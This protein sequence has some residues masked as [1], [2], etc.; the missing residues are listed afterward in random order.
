[1]VP[2]TQEILA[3][4]PAKNIVDPWR[5]YHY[6]V[7]SER[8]AAGAIEQVATIFLTNREC[9]FRCT[10]CDLWRNTLDEPTPLGAVPA[11]IDYALVRLPPADSIKLYNSGNFFD[12]QAIPPADH[13]AIAARVRGFKTVVVENHPR[14]CTP[15]CL[16]FRDLLS[17]ELE[18]ALGLET[19]HPQALAGLN[20]QMTVDGFRRAAEFLSG[21]RI[22]VRAFVLLK[23]PFLEEEAAVE[24][25]TRS[26]EVAFAAGARVCALIPTR[27]GNGAMEQLALQ[28]AF[29][30]PRLSSLERALEAG[31]ALRKGRVFADLWDIGRLATCAVCRDA[32]IERLSQMNLTQ[33]N[34]P[35]V[36]CVCRETAET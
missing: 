19:A 7:E 36:A 16:S 26:L 9:P 17:S 14:L 21:E 18:I 28:G 15:A 8:S 29:A 32:R 22:A 12:A 33:T 31:L 27:G 4:R 35:R 13:A 5:P 30:P 3:A 23:P 20:K 34:L 11:Q 25:A 10:M 6:L 1:M 2:T 24:W